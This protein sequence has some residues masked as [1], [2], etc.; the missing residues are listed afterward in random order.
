MELRP[1][2]PAFENP[3]QVLLG[4]SRLRLMAANATTL[5]DSIRDHMTT[6]E[7]PNDVLDHIVPDRASCSQSKNSRNDYRQFYWHGGFLFRQ[8]ILYVP[9]VS[10]DYKSYN[11]AMTHQ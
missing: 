6:D 1:G 3:K 5:L 7:F 8:N 11:I 2:E 10:H 9:N 4:H